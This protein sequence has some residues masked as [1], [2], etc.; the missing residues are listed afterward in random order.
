M[1]LVV[2][3]LTTATSLWNT[4]YLINTAARDSYSNASI[5]SNIFPNQTLLPTSK[6]YISDSYFGYLRQKGWPVTP[7][8]QGKLKDDS[9]ITVLGIDIIS[10]DQ[11]KMES[12]LPSNLDISKFLGNSGII[13]AA[14]ETGKRVKGQNLFENTVVTKGIPEGFLITDIS[15]AQKLLNLPGKL[16]SLEITQ[17]IDIK[18]IGDIKKLDLYFK[19]N[20]SPNDISALTKSFHLN[21]TAFGLLSYIVGLFIVYSTVNLAYEQRKGLLKSL[22]GIGISVRLISLLLLFEIITFALIA[23]ILGFILS[24]LLASSLLPNVAISLKNLFGTNIGETLPVNLQFFIFSL[25]VSILGAICSAGASLWKI[26][27]LNPLDTSKKFAWYEKTKENLKT[28]S[29]ISILLMFLIILLFKFS[30]SLLSSFILLGAFLLLVSLSLPIFLWLT[31]SII[32]KSKFERPLVHWFFADSRQQIDS[33][34][35]SLMAL[36]IALSVNIGVG[37]M[38]GSFKKT[39]TG[40]LDQRLVSELYVVSPDIEKSNEIRS[41]LSKKVDAILPIVKIAD[42]I[43]GELVDIY[44]FKVHE[45]YTDFWPLIDATD[46][47]WDKLHD[48]NG[49]LVNE[50]LARRLNIKPK[51][52][53]MINSSFGSKKRIEILGVYT[54]YGNPKGQIMIPISA[55]EKYYPNVPQLRFAI[56]VDQELVPEI[57]QELLTLLENQPNRIT[58]QS[59]VKELSTGIFDK[60]FAITS[61]LSLLTLGISGIALFTSI[62]ALGDNRSTQIA[63]LWALGL[64]KHHLAYLEALRALTLSLLTFIFAI[65]AGLLVVFILTNYINV[66]AFHWKLPIFFFPNQWIQLFAITIVMTFLAVLLHSIKMSKA[67]PSDLL[68]NSSYEI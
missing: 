8:L 11:K 1:F 2:I 61:A 28:Q 51:D 40:W 13:L 31:I 47:A 44:G 67:S 25:A 65:P 68:R 33:L 17:E 52:K 22:R 5:I 23:S 37:G 45:T 57:E 49:M 32:L 62:S 16:T 48:T 15:K 50:Q 26:S 6:K 41:E 42:K 14:D 20:Q 36:L 56:R 63:P 54:D 46:D 55:F 43:Q 35:V 12:I 19:R 21:L 4:V 10:S 30:N 3:G 24:L 58:N 34:S 38:V 39:F 7:R 53:L 29:L 64:Q 27:K 59:K 9:D 18:D 60:T 66:N